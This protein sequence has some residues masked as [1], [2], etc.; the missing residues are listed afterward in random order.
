MFF[1]KDKNPAV[2]GVKNIK[3]KNMKMMEE[4][5]VNEKKIRIYDSS[6]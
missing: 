2:G 5:T 4:V 1:K 3:K 6:S